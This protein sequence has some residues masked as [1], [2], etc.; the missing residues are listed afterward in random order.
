MK[1]PAGTGA[2]GVRTTDGVF[3]CLFVFIGREYN[4]VTDTGPLPSHSILLGIAINDMKKK[5]MAAKRAKMQRVKKTYGR[6][7]ECTRS[8]DGSIPNA[9]A[10]F[11]WE[12]EALW[13]GDIEYE[14]AEIE[15]PLKVAMMVARSLR[16][17]CVSVNIMRKSKTVA[18]KPNE[19]S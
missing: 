4:P 13:K 6:R 8:L 15:S 12:V 2:G 16:D 10:S 7:R 19:K 17:G 11:T 3:V 9:A 5:S 1:P 18:A 14:K